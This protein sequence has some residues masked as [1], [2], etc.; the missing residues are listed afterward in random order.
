MRAARRAA[1]VAD[2]RYREGSSDFLTLLDAQR[3]PLVTD[4]AP[5]PAFE[6]YATR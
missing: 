2:V 6:G 4:D 3:T 5:A 1:E